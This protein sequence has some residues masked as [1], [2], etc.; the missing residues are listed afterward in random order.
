[1]TRE[2]RLERSDAAAHEL[3]GYIARLAG[4]LEGVDADLKAAEKQASRE[5]EAAPT[6][7]GGAASTAAAVAQILDAD[8]EYQTLLLD[9]QSL[10]GQMRSATAT[11]EEI[12]I[13]AEV[14][15][16][17]VRRFERAETPIS[18]AWPVRRLF[19]AIAALIGFL[20]AAAIAWR[21]AEDRAAAKRS[22]DA[23]PYLR[24]PFLGDVP[25][26][27][28]TIVPWSARRS[29][30]HRRPLAAPYS[31][32][33][34]SFQY[35]LSSVLSSIRSNGHAPV[36]L[37]TGTDRHDGGTTTALNLGLAASHRR[38]R[39]VVIDSDFRDADLTKITGLSGLPGV[40]DGRDSELPAYDIAYE[41]R[42]KVAPTGD[43]FGDAISYLNSTHF[44]NAVSV[45]RAKYDLVILD[46][47]PILVAADALTAARA[48]DGVILVV[49]E[50]ATL[51]VLGKAA[52][53]LSRAPAP[54]LGYVFS[55]VRRNSLRRVGRSR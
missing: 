30:T 41:G 36:V 11:A 49:R 16:S 37:T 44:A 50:G 2:D 51:D 6:V 7:P 54:F 13:D 46:A 32:A 34:E 8:T 15:G 55:R 40:S 27:R 5:V 4:Q 33:E 53:V 35:I 29:F 18:P 38:L 19:A 48:A 23:T 39:V 45:A 28:S 17:G 14:V 9:R 47:P 25:P 42:L 26:L 1:V 43:T 52:R 20:G 12:R 22:Q 3:D 24:A 10:L 21:L 31:A